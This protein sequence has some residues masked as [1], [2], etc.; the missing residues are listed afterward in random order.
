[1]REM[2]RR[3]VEGV[4]HEAL[5]NLSKKYKIHL[6]FKQKKIYIQGVSK[7]VLG[8]A[9]SYH[10]KLILNSKLKQLYPVHSRDLT[11]F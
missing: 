7:R 3:I 1:M 2:M 11:A 6:G 10:S 5:E 8:R 4:E 9:W